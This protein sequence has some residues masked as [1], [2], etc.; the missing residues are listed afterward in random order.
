MKLAGAAVA[1]FLLAACSTQKNTTAAAP[2]TISGVVL[3]T[4]QRAPIPDYI[5]AT[6]TVRAAQS[7]QLASQVMGAITSVTVREGD[8][9]HRGQA[10]VSIDKA[11]PHAAYQSATAGWQASQ[12]AIATAD[13]DYT[14]AESTMQR[15]QVLYD[16]KSVSPHEYDEVKARLAAATAVPRAAVEFQMCYDIQKPLSVCRLAV[17]RRRPPADVTFGRRVQA[18]AWAGLFT[19]FVITGRLNAAVE[20]T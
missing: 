16:K 6:G 9:V 18:I 15:Y 8:A 14:L 12:Q 5:D 13:A 3:F 10:L 11:Q 20:P 17:V 1:T 19:S 7:A 4:A 2:E